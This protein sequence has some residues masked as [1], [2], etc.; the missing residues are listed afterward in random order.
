MF[1]V[2]FLHSYCLK[3]GSAFNYFRFYSIYANYFYANED[4]TC[5][6]WRIIINSAKNCNIP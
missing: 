2:K 4:F 6:S 3:R 1:L 5:F